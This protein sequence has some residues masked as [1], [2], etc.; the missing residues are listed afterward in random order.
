MLQ[1]LT[2][3]LLKAINDTPDKEIKL[4]DTTPENP[5]RVYLAEIIQL[6]GRVNVSDIYMKFAQLTMNSLFSAQDPSLLL[7]ESL[8]FSLDKVCEMSLIVAKFVSA[9][10]L[11]AEDQRKFN[12]K[13]LTCITSVGLLSLSDLDLILSKA[14]TEKKEPMTFA[15]EFILASVFSDKPI[16]L[17]SDFVNTI[18]AL[19]VTDVKELKED[20]KYI[21]LF[22]NLNKGKEFSFD[23]LKVM[24]LNAT[25]MKDYF[26]YVFAEWVKL[27]KFSDE[28]NDLQIAFINQLFDAGIFS[29]PE[30]LVSF[31]N[32]SIETSVLSFNKEGDIFKRSPVETYTAV[33][34]LAKLVIKL[35]LVQED[36]SSDNQSRCH[37]FKSILS[38]L[39]LSFAHDHEINKATFN[40]R[41]YFRFFSTLLSEWAAVE[42]SNYAINTDDSDVEKLKKF[43]SQF[44]YIIA[45]YLL[46]LQPAA[47]PGFTFAWV[48]LIS[49]RMFMP[50]L[51]EFTEEKSIAWSKFSSLL[52]V[53]LKFQSGYIKDKSIPEA[54]SVVYKGTLRIFLVLLHDFP[55]FL[56]EWANPLISEMSPLFTQLKNI[57]LS[58][59]PKNMQIPDPFQPGLKVDRLPE[60]TSIPEIAVDPQQVLLEFGIKKSVENYLRIPT[61]SLLKQILPALE[62]KETIAQ[63]GIGYKETSFSV[64]LINALVLQVGI[65]ATE[66]R[67]RDSLAFHHKSSQ[68]TLLSSIMQEGP[69]ELQFLLMQAVVNN[70]RYPNAH[71]HW[72]SCVVLHFF[73]SNNLWGDKKLNIQQLITRVLLERMI[74]NKPHPWGLMITF[75]ELMKN[76]DYSFF[77]L[78]FTKETPEFEKLFSSL[79][80]HV[81]NVPTNQVAVAAN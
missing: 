11:A 38:V 9:W 70:L 31:F 78:P 29:K 5:I 22:E 59:A 74:C 69:V 10:L 50:K 57:V 30:Y 28:N 68:V 15:C 27:T 42:Q 52:L 16:A 35:L 2:E 41:P 39:L 4:R 67:P 65:S 40:E 24:S 55:E 71:T 58:A 79:F 61:S 80:K 3:G 1:Q 13:I 18:G 73:G 53:L 14:V 48:C 54:L 7:I 46:S 6:L 33:D 37:F 44:Y 64:R 36:A 76:S 47:F 49:H 45:D 63:L 81:K 17:I 20:A 60:I 66:G 19:K 34:S 75:T 23:K 62:A 25:D 56:V 77:D 32:T 43:N 26:T 12:T 51:L 8:V 21:E 72:F